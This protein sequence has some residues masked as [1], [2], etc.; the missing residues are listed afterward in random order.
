MEKKAFASRF[1]WPVGVALGVWAGLNF[2]TDH[3]YWF[4]SGV[5][6]RAAAF[7]LYLLLGLLIAFGSFFLYPVLFFRGASLKERVIGSY[8]VLLLWVFVEIFRVSEYFTPGESVY[9]AFS[10]MPFGLM[11]YQVGYMSLCEMICRWRLKKN[12]VR[13]IKIFT[14]GPLIGVGVLLVMNYVM[15]FWGVP[16]ESP[17]TKWFYIYQEG[18]KALFTG[19]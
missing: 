1:L 9:Y 15:I 4:G 16:D 12:G 2:L 14:P 8:A 5:P 10:P 6:Y 17:G 13:G 3:L 7:S 18:Y 19:E 11:V